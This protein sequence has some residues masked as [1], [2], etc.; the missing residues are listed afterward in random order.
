MRLNRTSH[1]L[2]I[3]GHLPGRKK[4]VKPDEKNVDH[5]PHL[6]PARQVRHA[7]TGKVG[8][9]ACTYDVV[10][11]AP[12]PKGQADRRGHAP[13]AGLTAALSSTGLSMVAWTALPIDLD[14]DGHLDLLVTHAYDFAAFLLSDEGGAHPVFYRNLGN[15]KFA[16]LSKQVG[17]PAPHIGRHAALADLDNDGDLDLF[18]G[19]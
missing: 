9:S 16:D 15:G 3:A 14:V 1:V 6:G 5:P 7:P 10:T 12:L 13:Q 19:G 4:K 18:L 2:F 11:V 17:L 8:C